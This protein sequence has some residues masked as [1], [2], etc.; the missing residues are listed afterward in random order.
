MIM[1]NQDPTVESE[2]FKR[3]R[4]IKAWIEVTSALGSVVKH[5]KTIPSGHLYSLVMDLLTLD[6]YQQAISFLK[7][8]N[9]VSESNHLLTWTGPSHES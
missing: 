4:E 6:Q 9:L 5:K 2:T 3:K 8:T 7:N 1:K